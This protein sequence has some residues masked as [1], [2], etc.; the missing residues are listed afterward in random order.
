MNFMTQKLAKFIKGFKNKTASKK[1]VQRKRAPAKKVGKEKF[2]ISPLIFVKAKKNP[3][4]APKTENGWEAWQTFN[5]GVVL[6]ENKVHFLY[7][8]IG[9]DGISRFGYAVSSDGFTIDERLPY[10]VYEHKTS[11]RMFSIYSYLSGGSWGGSEDPRLVRIEKEDVL[12]MT[13][14]ACGNGLRV[15]LSSIKVDDFLNKKWEWKPPAL[16][17]PPGEIHK[18]WLIFPEKINDKYAILHSIK[19]TIQIEYVDSLEFDENNHINSF[20]GGGPQKG[21]WDKWLRGA[22]AP[23]LK[24]CDGWLL[25]YHA[26]DGDFSKYKV[27]AMLLDLADPTKILYRSKEPVLVPEELY[28]NNGYKPGVVYVSGAVV[29][30]ENLLIYYGCSD[31]YVS[32]AHTNLNKFL[33]ALKKETKPKLKLKTL[34]KK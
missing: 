2:P 10:P 27:G 11:K 14:T 13:Y 32:V 20:H 30:D 4:I 17:S 1:G 29:K 26:V 12:Y 24:T 22:G 28:E 6:L 31:S 25:F 7:R 5:P 15:G 19:P 9:E 23:P 8:A 3:I 33:E 16:I 18:N 34:K 21:C